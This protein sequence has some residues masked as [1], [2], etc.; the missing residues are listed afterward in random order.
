MRLQAIF[1]Y[2]SYKVP[3]IFVTHIQRHEGLD[4]IGAMW[5]DSNIHN[6]RNPIHNQRPLI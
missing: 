5:H 1:Y 4:P 6:T 2:N 3:K